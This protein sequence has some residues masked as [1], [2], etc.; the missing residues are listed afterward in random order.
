MTS[1]S[2]NWFTIDELDANT[3]VISEYKHWEETHCYLLNGTNK[4]LLIDTGLGVENIWEQVQKLT[5]NPVTAVAT[6]VHYDHI[7]GH[8]YFNDIYVHEDETDWLNGGFPLSIEQ[9]RNFL[10]E[11]PCDFPKEFDVNNYYLFEG[12]PTRVLSDNDTIE[13][14][15][16][17]IQVLHTPGHSPGHIC[18]YEKDKGYLFTGDLIYLGKLFAYFPSTDPIAYM[19]SIKKLLSLSVKRILPAHHDLDVPLSV[20][21]DMDH[22][23]TQL[24]EKGLLK[25]GSGTFS[26]SNFEIQL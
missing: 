25:H 15:E 24:Y 14:G 10:I 1:K 5:N 26:Y 7:G 11:E 18:F 22:A 3:F 23:F 2:E 6:H 9:V 19:H 16:R 21:K 4:S 12:T 20:I 17:T 8:K 13:L